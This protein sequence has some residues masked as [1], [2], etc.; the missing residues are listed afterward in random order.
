MTVIARHA[1]E[2]T[3][4]YRWL[5]HVI[6]ITRFRIRLGQLIGKSPVIQRG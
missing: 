6:A 2:K 5:C 4:K 1:G 3:W